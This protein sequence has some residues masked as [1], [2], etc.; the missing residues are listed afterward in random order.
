MAMTRIVA[1]SSQVALFLFLSMFGACFIPGTNVL[2][3]RTQTSYAFEVIRGA[4]G[5]GLG[6]LSHSE[7]A[8]GINEIIEIKVR[9][10][11][12]EKSRMNTPEE[13]IDTFKKWGDILAAQLRDD[14]LAYPEYANLAAKCAPKETKDK[15]FVQCFFY[16]PNKLPVKKGEF[17]LDGNLD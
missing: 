3:I 2:P 16:D 1:Y 15:V 8:L 13:C 4:C 7:P 9:L 14:F 17:V 10:Y 6:A 12:Y 11:G 5:D